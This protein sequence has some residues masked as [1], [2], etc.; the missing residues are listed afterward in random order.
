[1]MQV[2]SAHLLGL[3][4]TASSVSVPLQRGILHN[5]LLQRITPLKSDHLFH[6]TSAM[7]NP[8]HR[9]LNFTSMT[10]HQ[11]CVRTEAQTL[12]RTHSALK[13]LSHVGQG[14]RLAHSSKPLGCM[15]TT[16]RLSRTN[17]G[18]YLFR[19]CPLYAQRGLRVAEPARFN[20]SQSRSQTRSAWRERNKSVM[21][22]VVAGAVLVVGFSYAAV[23]L[24]TV[25]C[26][27]MYPCRILLSTKCSRTTQE[28]PALLK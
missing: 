5:N 18:Q 7:S 6:S 25:F 22:Y 27:V 2:S 23:P 4:R 8:V 20:S 16:S 12:F 28:I 24:Y 15:S 26:Q 9:F 14:C 1:M 10:T 13:S 19:N 3:A 11:G 17:E 21:L